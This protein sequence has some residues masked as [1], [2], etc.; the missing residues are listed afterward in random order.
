MGNPTQ[1]L[2]TNVQIVNVNP[3]RVTTPTQQQNKNMPPRFMIPQMVGSRPGQPGVSTEFV[4]FR[5]E[6]VKILLMLSFR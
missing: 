2:P 1:I 5:V 4:F 6:Y 3:L